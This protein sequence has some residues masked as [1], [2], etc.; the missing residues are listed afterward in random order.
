MILI[1]IVKVIIYLSKKKIE[2]FIE[3]NDSIKGY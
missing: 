1:S 3:M 2:I